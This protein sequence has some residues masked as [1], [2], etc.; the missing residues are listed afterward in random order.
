MSEQ[1][2][3][4]S[5]T[6]LTRYVKRLFEKDR[7]L[8]DIWVRGELSNF[9]HHSRG[10][11]YFT[12]K[13][14]NSRIQ[15]VMFAS[16]NRT[17]GFRPEDGMKVLVRGE[18]SVYEPY[19]TYQLYAKEMQ[20]DGIG[21][22]YLAF[23]ELKKKLTTEGLFSE[24]HKKPLPAVPYEIGVITSPTGAA[25]RDIFTTVKRRFPAA[26]ITLFPVLVQGTSA[27]A[28]I[29][30]A[31]ERANQSGFI[32]VLIVGRGG[33]S[34][35][36]LWAFNEEIVAR[37]IFASTL[38]VISAV[39][40]E[41]DY[42]IADFVADMRAPTPTAAGELAVPHFEELAAR[43]HDR[44]ARLKR[45]MAERLT[46]EKIRLKRMQTSYAFRY[47]AQLVRQ[48]E[49][50]LDRLME[51]LTRESRR[52]V[53]KPAERFE[54]VYKGLRKF[55]PEE[56]LRLA[57]ER[58]Q[59]LIKRLNREMGKVY[60]DKASMFAQTVSKLNVLSPLNVMERGFSLT[61][62]EDEKLVKSIR[63]VQLGDVLKV[64]LKDGQLDCH[65]WGM[66]ERKTN[67]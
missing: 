37:T 64:Q 62:S 65:V 51:R 5:V 17:L 26:R 28:S 1:D 6:A 30:S 59:Q 52:A 35:E 43:I 45:A 41:T 20:P 11:M 16:S 34:I 60:R 24:E 29:A 66:E 63:Q 40:H 10:H 61:Y 3:Y 38:P 4:I 31:I 48:K 39:G 25:V 49:Q 21:N 9:K 8:G 12:L 47:P 44:Q 42:T 67:E 19:G 33:G 15:S 54:A 22:L 23:E 7:R 55:H 46:A 50:E 32:E 13:D 14:Q 27:A 18:V 57:K 53:E 36:E 58:H 56:T 2:R